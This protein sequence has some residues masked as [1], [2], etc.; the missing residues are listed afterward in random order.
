MLTAEPHNGPQETRRTRVRHDPGPV[1]RTRPGG[2]S[3]GASHHVVPG[4]VR[5]AYPSDR[6]FSGVKGSGEC[7]RATGGGGG[8]R[9]GGREGGG[10]GAGREGGGDR[11][12][13]GQEEEEGGVDREEGGGTERE[14][15]RGGQEEKGGGTRKE[16]E[17]GV[18]GRRGAGRG[19][20]SILSAL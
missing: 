1:H 14:G 18:Q 10:G 7:G 15:V 11:E 13:G 6:G 12:G 8:R 20:S 5:A 3:H 4:F 2:P 16:E 9:E 19:G 17:W